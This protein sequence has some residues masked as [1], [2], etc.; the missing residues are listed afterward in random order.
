MPH[1]KAICMKFEMHIIC[2]QNNCLPSNYDKAD[3]F[4]RNYIIHD[5]T[6]VTQE[7]NYSYFYH[8]CNHP[9]YGNGTNESE[10]I[11]DQT[12]CVK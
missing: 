2:F 12:V 7:G 1:K 10:I 4:C 11:S 6:D 8:L 9:V 3:Q 5:L